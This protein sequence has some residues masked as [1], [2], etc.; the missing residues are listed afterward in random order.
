MW[1]KYIPTLRVKYSEEEVSKIKADWEARITFLVNL[2]QS[3][4]KGFDIFKL[5]SDD[6]QTERGLSK[7]FR[8]RINRDTKKKEASL[9]AIFY[10][11]EIKP[12]SSGNLVKDCSLVFYTHTKTTRPWI[13]LFV[14]TVEECGSDTVLI[15]VEWLRKEKKEFV[16][17]TP[18]QF[19]VLDIDSIMFCD[20][21]RNISDGNRGGPYSLD[22]E[23]KRQIMTA[24][25]ERDSA[26]T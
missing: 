25:K 20:I 15:K 1:S 4:F 5:V 18:P 9:T 17:N 7:S 3:Q 2:D 14:E 16:I 23:S 12:F 8:T 19:S 21:L 22:V 13:G 26:L 10:Q 6:G 11:P 24:Y